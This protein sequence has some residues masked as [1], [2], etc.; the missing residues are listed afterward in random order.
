MVTQSSQPVS[1]QT[2]F[3]FTHIEGTT[4]GIGEEVDEV[5]GG[6]SGMVMDRIPEVGD[7]ANEGQAAGVYVTGFRAGSPPKVGVRDGSWGPGRNFGTFVF[8]KD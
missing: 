1:G 6:A 4:L 8:H 7:R 3:C 2:I 5:A